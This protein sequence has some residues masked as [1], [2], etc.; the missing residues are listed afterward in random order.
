M[1]GKETG[2]VAIARG[3]R[4]PAAIAFLVYTAIAFLSFGL[5]VVLRG[6]GAYVGYGVDPQIFVW[7]FGWWPH[8][9]LHG[10]NPVITHAIWAPAG[11]NLTWATGVP[12]LAAVFAP[13]TLLFGPVA[14]YN[15]AATLMPALAAWTC[16]LLCRRLTRSFWA[17]FIGGYLF[18][19][20]SYMLG[21]QEGHMHMTSVF[22]I[23]LIALAFVR[24]LQGEIGSRK[25]ALQLGALFFLQL[26]FSTELLLTVSLAILV[27]LLVAFAASPPLRAR[28]RSLV[29]PLGQ[30]Y[31]LVLVIASPFVYYAVKGFEH[32]SINPPR[33]FAAD[34]LNFV[35]P[36]RLLLV[37]HQRLWQIAEHFPGNDSERGAYIGLPV[38]V[39]VALFAR[40][41]WRLPYSRVLLLWL[42]VAML[43]ELGAE[44][45]VDG[46]SVV[47]L[48]VALVDH[49]PLLNN[50]LPVRISL[51][52]S[53]ITAVI[54]ALFVAAARSPWT[55]VVLPLLALASLLP[56]PGSHSWITVT[57][58]PRFITD[59]LY[60]TCLTRGETV[61]VLPFGSSGDSML[62]QARSDYWFRLAGGF[63]RP[64]VPSAF[65][66]FRVVHPELAPKTTARDVYQFARAT[67]AGSVIVD[68]RRGGPWR[69]VLGGH[70]A[71]VGGVLIYPVPGSGYPRRSCP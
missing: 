59:G 28:I 12:G 60:K 53:L 31:L 1:V 50:V 52:A 18:G 16:F 43:V 65:T 35:L 70:P 56:R 71:S 57:A 68:E 39:I 63:L 3:L 20:S 69:A 14:A 54:V 11:L 47:P 9:L 34:L 37:D 67:G 62:W 30:A 19:F 22:L 45:H 64:D 8:A 38:L 15:V 33:S 55:R 42:G 21:Q 4:T 17:S 41:H 7:S 2:A 51:F 58:Q 25:L 29:V 6:D 27:A 40:S 23:P 49:W 46:H 26:L 61:V 44:L 32:H 24:R 36:T 13:V 66:R 5:R 10:E 48:P